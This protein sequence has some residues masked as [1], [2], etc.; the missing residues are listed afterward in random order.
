MADST[1]IQ[2]FQPSARGDFSFHSGES[3]ALSIPS[4]GVYFSGDKYEGVG[5]LALTTKRVVWIPANSSSS[6]AATPLAEEAKG[7]SKTTPIS[8]S[9]SE[10]SAAPAEQERMCGISFSYHTVAMHSLCR[11]VSVFPF[12]CLMCSLDDFYNTQIRFVIASESYLGKEDRSKEDL[13]VL[14]T[15]FTKCAHMNPDKELVEK[16]KG[17]SRSKRTFRV[18]MQATQVSETGDMQSESESA[19]AAGSIDHGA[20]S[21]S[22]EASDAMVEVGQREEGEGEGGEGG[23]RYEDNDDDS[24][25]E[26][27]YI[28]PRN[29]QVGEIGEEGEED[30]QDE[31]TVLRMLSVW[32]QKFIEPQGGLV[33]Q[34][35]SK[36]EDVNEDEHMA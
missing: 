11:D 7:Q 5:C 21:S 36:T 3:L 4:V 14:Y 35:S 9:E 20:L 22:A 12:P 34:Q 18:R 15:T 6:N 25:E 26:D 29:V 24:E 8:K 33:A 19:V 10:S 16:R 17:G 31:E 30:E 1:G 28:F 32:D 27:D 23:E 2:R 13:S